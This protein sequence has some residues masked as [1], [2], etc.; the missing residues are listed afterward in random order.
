[1]DL[2]MVVVGLYSVLARRVEFRTSMRNE[3][4]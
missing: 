1:M 3:C 2:R 4:A